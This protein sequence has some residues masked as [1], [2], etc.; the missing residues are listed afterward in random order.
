VVGEVCHFIDLLPFLAGAPINRVSAIAL[1]NQG[2]YRDDNI[3]ISLTLADGSIGVVHYV[4][5]GAKELPKEYLEVSCEGKTAVLD[6][7]RSLRL[8]SG[9]SSRVVRGR[10]DKGHRAEMLAWIEAIQ[11]G[12]PEP[13]PFDQAMSTTRATFAARQSLR[14]G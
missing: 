11:T 9:G 10:Q 2:K 4:A 7:F 13:V 12:E 1:P 8:F 14:E 6:D 3:S 5:N